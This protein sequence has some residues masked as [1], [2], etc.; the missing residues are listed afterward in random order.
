MTVN[1]YGSEFE[2]LPITRKIV[3]DIETIEILTYLPN[4]VMCVLSGSRTLSDEKKSIELLSMSLAGVKINQEI[5]S[6]RV[7]YRPNL[8]TQAPESIREY[9]SYP[10]SGQQVWTHD[11]CVLFD[12]FDPDPFAYLLKIGNKIKF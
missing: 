1:A 3:N 11:G 8:S 10:S 4:T 5:M 7:D 9:V 6:N 2:L 12:L